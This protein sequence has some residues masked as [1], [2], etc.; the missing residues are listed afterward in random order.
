MVS[1]G[2][3]LYIVEAL[4]RYPCKL[5]RDPGVFCVNF[6]SP[7]FEEETLCGT[8]SGRDTDK[9]ADTFFERKECKEINC[10]Y[11][12]AKTGLSARWLTR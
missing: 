8:T 6:V 7:E 2:I 10:P 12:S 5:I 1:V 4:R 3:S 11:T 9:F